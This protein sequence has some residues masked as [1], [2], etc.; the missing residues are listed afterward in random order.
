MTK[1][2]FGQPITATDVERLP[3]DDGAS[4]FVRLCGTLI[5]AALAERAGVFTFPEITE[6]VNVPDRGVDA[7]YTTPAA[8]DIAETGGLVGPGKTVYQCKYRDVAAGPRGALLNG[9]V[10]QLRKDLRRAVPECNRYVFLTNL[11]LSAAHRTRLRETLLGQ[12]PL[13]SRAVV[14]WGAAEIAQA[15][16]AAPRLRHVFFSR[17]G[18]CSLD[19]A[20]SELRAAYEKVGWPAF[21]GR[22][23]E[24]RAIAGFADDPGARYLE[25]IGPPYSGRTR[26]VIEALEQRGASVLWASE[27]QAATL[28]LFRELD[29][30]ESPGILVVDACTPG[31]L[32]G[33][34]DRALSRQRLKTIAVCTGGER[35]AWWAE[36]GRVVVDRL[37]HG[38]AATLVRSVLPGVAPLQESWIIEAS[39]GV[40]GL[41]L[42][43]ASL[44]RDGAVSPTSDPHTVQ[45]RLGDLVLDQY[46]TRAELTRE[47]REWLDVASVLSA[48]GVEGDVRQEIDDV[49]AALGVRSGTFEQARDEL[50]DRGLVRR[51]GRFV[52]VVPP[53]L[54]EELASRALSRSETALAELMLRLTPAAFLRFLERFRNL[55]GD[56]TKKT[57]AAVL[58][59][60]VWFPD[61]SALERGEARFRVLVPAAPGEALRCLERLLGS[62]S[63][64][65]LLGR[66]TGDFRLSVVSALDDLTLGSRT[67]RGAARLLLALSEGETEAFGN[68]ARQ[69]FVSLFHWKHPEIAAPLPV[70]LEVLEEG[71]G[72]GSAARRAVVAK[73]CGMAFSEHGIIFHHDSKGAAVPE[74]PARP[75]TWEEVRC[76]GLGVL[77]V[78]D[79]LIADPEPAVDGEAVASLLEVSRPFIVVSLLP[80]GFH[81]L[82][83]KT[84][85]GLE[86][87]ARSAKSAR[88]RA[89]VVS[90]LELILEDLQKRADVE[91]EGMAGAVVGR[92]RALIET[93]TLGSP[94]DRLW[95]WVGP[96]TWRQE[97]DEQCSEHEA[98]AIRSVAAD[99]VTKP[100]TL[101]EELP[102][103]TTEDAERR[104]LLF[105]E[106]G[107]QDRGE[108]LLDPILDT[109]GDRFWPGAVAAYFQG[110]HEAEP[111]AAGRALD[112]LIASRPDLS[113]GT[114]AATIY[115]PTSSDTP[116]RVRRIAD[117]GRIPRPELARDLALGLGWERLSASDAEELIASLDDGS[118]ETRSALLQ[119]FWLRLVRGAEV[120][121]GLESLGWSFLESTLPVYE[122]RGR[123]WGWDALAAKLGERNPKRLLIL[124]ERLMR[125]NVTAGR[126]RFQ[127]SESLPLTWKTLRRRERSGVLHVLLGLALTSDAPYWLD[128]TLSKLIQPGE[129]LAALMA[130][131]ER[132]GIEGARVV[133]DV[134]D[135]EKPGFWKLARELVARWG[136]DEPLAERLGS[137]TLSGAWAGSPV[138]MISGRMQGAEQ[139]LSDTDPK[140]VRWAQ[141][142]LADLEEWQ[143][144]AAREDRED[145]IWDQRISRAELEGMLDRKD[146]PERVWAIGRLLKDA[147]EERV[148]ELLSPEDILEALP[149]LGHL[150]ERTRRKW[151]SWARHWRRAD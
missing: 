118:A 12:P 94:K 111:E 55:P 132:A 35:E 97:V 7:T 116:H 124:F 20:K 71:A 8:L 128:W 96:R 122:D 99:L 113:T 63:A 24:R 59:T 129:D 50:E 5:G 104:S 45:H 43:V 137:R 98:E 65:E 135:A 120:G 9:I 80:D 11:D 82:G 127:V 48:V 131:A 121:A 26:L 144:T 89:A 134:A 106:L 49:A 3:P 93:L 145:W 15:L 30:H 77:G 125:E 42:H 151:E 117:H 143:K 148:R 57:V 17:G 83:S 146:A 115:L 108:R 51:R 123:N 147:P 22:Q 79:R 28:D 19:T 32:A 67:F 40:P 76:Y 25:V 126:R 91:P 36:P 13:A 33:I 103:L 114:L 2:V 34:R 130:F 102:W 92:I 41:V 139:L 70:R 141:Q 58:G 37:A 23:A 10:Q 53:R 69:A 78:L 14:A 110:W 52:E 95:H 138:P 88:Q 61:L 133:A 16:N 47:A 31:V 90:R 29:S 74:G 140:V 84:L 27:P 64:E 54:A 75:R 6:R 66:V 87:V 18:L 72:S 44:L 56:I 136:Q 100:D 107:K 73:A 81:D 142:V 101:V 112:A 109:R 105:G 1:A 4:S 149:K 62:L 38:D 60:G 85:D 21:V 46:V 150:D 119:A 86:K 39:G 68:S